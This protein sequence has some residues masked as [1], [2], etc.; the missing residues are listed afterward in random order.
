MNSV[1]RIYVEVE[2]KRLMYIGKSIM[3]AHK[4]FKIKMKFSEKMKHKNFY[5]LVIM[6]RSIKMKFTKKIGS[7][8]SSYVTPSCSVV[9]PLVRTYG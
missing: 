7:T 1:M 9:P 2:V 5:N 4:L 3:V 8:S 6:V